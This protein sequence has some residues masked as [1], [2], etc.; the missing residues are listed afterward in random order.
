[1][2]NGSPSPRGEGRGEGDRD[3]RQPGSSTATKQALERFM[4][5]IGACKRSYGLGVCSQDRLLFGNSKKD[6][7]ERGLAI[8][9]SPGTD[10]F[11][12]AERYSLASVEDH[13]LVAQSLDQNQQ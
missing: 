12:R 9:G 10:F 7:L 11:E 13:H 4:G 8:Q 3:V 1:M 6:I 5:V 2:E